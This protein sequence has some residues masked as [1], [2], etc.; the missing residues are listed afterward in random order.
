MS[1][2]DVEAGSAYSKVVGSDPC[3]SIHP[4]HSVF[5]FRNRT[6]NAFPP[7]QLPRVAEDEEPDDVERDVGEALLAVPAGVVHVGRH[8]GRGRGALATAELRKGGRKG[9][10]IS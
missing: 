1:R 3:H 7:H 2:M 6:L 9:S 10:F 4:C 5:F 8:A